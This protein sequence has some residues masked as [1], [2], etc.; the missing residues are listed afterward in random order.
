MSNQLKIKKIIGL[1]V[2]LFPMMS[3]AASTDTADVSTTTPA[4]SATAP[5]TETT[6]TTTTTTPAA[7]PTEMSKDEWLSKIKV[8][9]AEPVCKGFMDDPSIS[10]RLNEQGITLEKCVGLIP[11]INDK[12]QKQF[13]DSLPAMINQ[14]SASTWG[15]KIGECIGGDFAMTYL[16]PKT[17]GTAAPTGATAPTGTTAPQALQ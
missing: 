7:E 8:V 15:R 11:A 9:V 1:G 16:Y 14:E 6:T 3:L 17:D 5:T 4:A 12:C 2:I 13:Y 10:A